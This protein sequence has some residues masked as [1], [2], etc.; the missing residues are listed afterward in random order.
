MVGVCVCISTHWRMNT[1]LDRQSQNVPCHFQLIQFYILQQSPYTDKRLLVHYPLL[2]TQSI[3]AHRVQT[4][5]AYQVKLNSMIAIEQLSRI[6]AQFHTPFENGRPSL[7]VMSVNLCIRDKQG[8]H[9]DSAPLNTHPPQLQ[10][11][12]QPWFWGGRNPKHY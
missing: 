4:T 2:Y 1:P 10:E 11:E 9:L 12:R 7:L 8:Q 5:N 6:L 3:K